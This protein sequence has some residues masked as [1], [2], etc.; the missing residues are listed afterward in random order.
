MSGEE[1]SIRKR[2]KEKGEKKKTKG[3]KKPREVRR[4]EWGSVGGRHRRKKGEVRG[5]KKNQSVFG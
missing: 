3:K 2:E 5:W 4:G 1:I